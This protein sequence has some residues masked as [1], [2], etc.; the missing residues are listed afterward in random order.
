MDYPSNST[1]QKRR[2]SKRAIAVI[3]VLVVIDL[4]LLGAL[5]YKL[6]QRGTA[7]SAQKNDALALKEAAKQWRST[8]NN[9]W[10]RSCVVDEGTP[11]LCENTQDRDEIVQAAGN[12]S[13]NYS[14]YVVDGEFVEGDITKNQLITYGLSKN[15]LILV[16]KSNCFQEREVIG[17][18]EFS[19]IYARTDQTGQ[20]ATCV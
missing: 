12:F 15:A 11:K 9:L 1:L 19:V 10:P 20:D 14:V 7:G 8:H 18:S 3:I 6:Q 13:A 4:A 17:G 2:W 5:G 16:S